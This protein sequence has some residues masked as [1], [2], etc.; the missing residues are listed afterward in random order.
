MTNFIYAKLVLAVFL[1]FIPVHCGVA[2]Q[3]VEQVELWSN[4]VVEAVAQIASEPKVPTY[5][6]DYHVDLAAI[7][8]GQHARVLDA[9][10]LF[11]RIG[12][13]K[14]ARKRE[15]A[16]MFL[17]DGLSTGDFVEAAL[18]ESS[19][20]ENEN[21]RGTSFISVAIRQAQRGDFE[22]A[23]KLLERI[24]NQKSRDRAVAQICNEYAEIS[25]FEDAQKLSASIAD[26][27]TR[28]DVLAKIAKRKTMPKILDADYV[29]AKIDSAKDGVFGSASEAELTFLNHYYRAEVAYESKDTQRFDVEI[30][31]AQ[32]LALTMADNDASLLMLARLLF[33]ANR[34]D[35]AKSL[36]VKLFDKYLARKDSPPAFDFN[37]MLFGSGQKSDAW[38][39][40]YC[41][42]D[43]ELK[44]LL[45]QLSERDSLFIVAAPVFGA[46]IRR[47]NPEWAEGMYRDARSVKL[48][49]ELAVNSLFAL[50]QKD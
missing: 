33:Q 26:R 29:Q 13:N 28:M 50:A 12:L 27:N 2:Q 40:A 4:R 11:D 7:A 42:P 43:D 22:D 9:L 46:A 10:K 5:E 45:K 49:A 3:D 6:L 35:D 21:L 37:Q 47:S 25:K 14:D 41:T 15:V 38:I 8:L 23:V 39:V 48:R 36:Y 32:M 16:L 44:V 30:R 20:I 17:A 19:K 31:A 1:I 34:L 24:P 18:A